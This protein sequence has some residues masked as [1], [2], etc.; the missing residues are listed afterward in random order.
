[1]C[2]RA[3]Q[4]LLF[5]EDVG[6]MMMKRMKKPSLASFETWSW[7]ENDRFRSIDECKCVP[8]KTKASHPD[9]VGWSMRRRTRFAS[10]GKFEV[11]IQ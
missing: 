8:K 10:E 1:M 3:S 7:E 11:P 9:S 6:R 2:H 4:T 5:V